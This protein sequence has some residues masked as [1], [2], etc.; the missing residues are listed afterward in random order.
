MP[1]GAY[2]HCLA[3]CTVVCQPRLKPDKMDYSGI[4]GSLLQAIVLYRIKLL[5]F[6]PN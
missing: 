5:S 4:R 1:M 6:M 2:A 3:Q